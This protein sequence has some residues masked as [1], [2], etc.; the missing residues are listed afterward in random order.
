LPARR[1]L[2]H[3]YEWEE[4]EEFDVGLYAKAGATG[5]LGVG[6]P[7]EL[8]GGAATCSTRWSP[9]RRCCGAAP[10]APQ[11]GSAPW[12]SP[13]PDLR[14]GNEEQKRRF[15]TPVL[16]GEKISAL[17]ITEP[18]AGSDVAGL[19]TR[20][21]RD[22]DSY[23]LDGAK[24]FI[25]SV[26]RA[27]CDLRPGPDEPDPHQGLT[28]SWSKRNARFTVSKALKKTA[29]G[30]RTPASCRSIACGCRSRTASATRAPASTRSCAT[31]ST[32]G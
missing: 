6:F 16:R 26:W 28:S 17:A 30:L 29:G 20:A 19:R 10:P 15:A 11:P 22:G 1:I 5:M 13:C 9:A 23:L 3:A 25:T 27:R 18:G 21:V 8:G 2:P 24:T 32:S 14:P 12:K 7:E 4:A 31:S